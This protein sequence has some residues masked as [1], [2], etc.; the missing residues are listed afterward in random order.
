MKVMYIED[1]WTNKTFVFFEWLQA[2][3]QLWTQQHG[4]HSLN[5]FAKIRE[6]SKSSAN[7]FYLAH[8]LM[9]EDLAK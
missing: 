2:N 1:A 4:R 3:T 5:S 9:R 7:K 6:V 8:P